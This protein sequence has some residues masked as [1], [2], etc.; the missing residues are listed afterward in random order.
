MTNEDVDKILTITLSIFQS[1]DC[2]I[3]LLIQVENIQ[4]N[5]DT[6]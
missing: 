2:L 4:F 5:Q 6:S 3:W 1:V